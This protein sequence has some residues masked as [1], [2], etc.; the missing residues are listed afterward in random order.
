MKG[1]I[2]PYPTLR[3]VLSCRS[4]KYDWM[5]LKS[6]LLP[7]LRGIIVRDRPAQYSL[8]W[9]RL[10]VAVDVQSQPNVLAEFERTRSSGR[11]CYRILSAD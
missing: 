8:H 1:M 6:P 11:N 4:L 3:A 5:E 2:F 7:L 9:K 10:T